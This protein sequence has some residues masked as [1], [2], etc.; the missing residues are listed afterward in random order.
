MENM[1]IIKQE[2]WFAI[3]F[4]PDGGGE[5]VWILWYQEII[6]STYFICARLVLF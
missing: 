4:L 2:M 3:L 6:G 5:S 1:P